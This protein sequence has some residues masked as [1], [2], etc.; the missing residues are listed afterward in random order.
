MTEPNNNHD[1]ALPKKSGRPVGSKTKVSGRLTSVLGSGRTPTEKTASP[2]PSDSGGHPE[3]HPTPRSAV[4]VEISRSNQDAGSREPR[5]FPVRVVEMRYRSAKSGTKL[6][7]GDRPAAPVRLALAFD[8][9]VRSL[10]EDEQAIIAGGVNV[11]LPDFSVGDREEDDGV[12]LVRATENSSSLSKNLN[13]WDSFA[14]RRGRIVAYQTVDFLCE[15]CGKFKEATNHKYM[16]R[17]GFTGDDYK[18]MFALRHQLGNETLYRAICFLME[19]FVAIRAKQTS[20]LR[21]KTAPTIP[22]LFALINEVTSYMDAP[23]PRKKRGGE[24][25][26]FSPEVGDVDDDTAQIV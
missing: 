17:G 8:A 6:E 7:L 21:L 19:E 4:S 3:V 11:A 24:Q 2:S 20:S 16:L 26:E 15:F 5:Q 23:N 12:V 22:V 13:P 1:N 18:K 14:R 10:P 25:S 9:W